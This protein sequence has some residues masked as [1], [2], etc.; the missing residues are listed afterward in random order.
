MQPTGDSLQLQGWHLYLI[1]DTVW[2]QKPRVGVAILVGDITAL[3]PRKVA[4]DK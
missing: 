4:R 3:K 1:K 2:K